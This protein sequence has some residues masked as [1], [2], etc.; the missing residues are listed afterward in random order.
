MGYEYEHSRDEQERAQDN[1][2]E[3]KHVEKGV[4]HA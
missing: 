3:W 4:P 2:D 1:R